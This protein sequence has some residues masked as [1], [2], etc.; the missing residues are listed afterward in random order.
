MFFYFLIG[1]VIAYCAY[2]DIPI[3]ILGI[4]SVLYLYS[5]IIA[6]ISYFIIGSFGD[7]H[8][9]FLMNIVDAVVAFFAIRLAYL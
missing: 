7:Y 3:G 1:A 5:F 9:S 6:I 8:K 2:L 4:F